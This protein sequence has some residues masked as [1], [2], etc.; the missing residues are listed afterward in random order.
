MN[1][2]L[3]RFPI[4]RKRGSFLLDHEASG[5]ENRSSVSQDLNDH[6]FTVPIVLTVLEFLQNILCCCQSKSHLLID[7]F[8][9]ADGMIQIYHS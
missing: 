5:Q 6:L 3:P 1:K 7:S 8:H 4:E 9:N 2:K